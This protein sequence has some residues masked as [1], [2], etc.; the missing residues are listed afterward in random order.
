[1]DQRLNQR[2]D[3]NSSM[4]PKHMTWVSKAFSVL[5]ALCKSKGLGSMTVVVS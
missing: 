5:V 4:P 3:S 2:L 1:M